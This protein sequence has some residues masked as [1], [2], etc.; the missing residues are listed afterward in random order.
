MLFTPPGGQTGR[1]Q[2]Q[3]PATTFRKCF[4]RWS[5]A[6]YRTTSCICRGP[7]RWAWWVR[8][9]VLIAISCTPSRSNI[10]V[11]EFDPGRKLTDLLAAQ[12]G[13]NLLDESATFAR[14]RASKRSPR[15]HKDPVSEHT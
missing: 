4:G 11:R 15:A 14:N 12:G 3:A 7:R 6:Q 10:S 2:H 13:L 1:Q 9:S 8:G 5:H